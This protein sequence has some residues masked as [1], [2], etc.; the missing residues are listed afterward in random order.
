MAWGLHSRS[1]FRVLALWR[2]GILIAELL[3]IAPLGGAVTLQTSKSAATLLSETRSASLRR[4]GDLHPSQAASLELQEAFK[5]VPSEIFHVLQQVDAPVAERAPTPD[6]EVFRLRTSELLR[7]KLNSMP[8]ASAKVLNKTKDAV[9]LSQVM[10]GIRSRINSSRTNSSANVNGGDFLKPPL[11]IWITGFARSGS[12]TFLSM[13][14]TAGHQASEE[15]ALGEVD[16]LSQSRGPRMFAIFEPCHEDTVPEDTENK[17]CGSMMDHFFDCN[18]QGFT[19]VH[20]WTHDHSMTGNA[21]FELDS[22]TQTCMYSDIIAMKTVNFT[23]PI[24]KEGRGMATLPLPYATNL[25]GLVSY[26]LEE[27]FTLRVVNL[28]RDPRAIVASWFLTGAFNKSIVRSP[29]TLTSI[30]DAFLSN[31]ESLQDHPRV[32]TV[33]FE[34]F[35]TQPAATSKRVFDFLGLPYTDVQEEWIQETFSPDC[36]NKK[37][38]LFDDCHQNPELSIERWRDELTMEEQKAFFDH[39]SCCKVASIYGYDA[40]GC[41]QNPWG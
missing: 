8:N 22:A 12:S 4:G 16:M 31:F 21:P 18:F 19:A 34:N 30:C 6:K 32:T 20:G 39:P 13:V 40:Q 5:A 36:V 29:E 10:S 24:P 1:P 35:V 28:V 15:G 25:A 3:S 9:G 11:K 7:L 37:N 17:D 23:N 38:A 33:V 41:M 26:P 14:E 2:A 27:H